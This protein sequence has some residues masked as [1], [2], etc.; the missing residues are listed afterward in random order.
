MLLFRAGQITFKIKINRPAN[1]VHFIA[2]LSGL[3]LAQ[4]KAAVRNH[5]MVLNAVLKQPFLTYYM[6][7][8]QS[9]PL[10]G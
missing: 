2:L 8:I 5:Y 7:Q 1:M 6:L 4:Y 10:M 3:W 9:L